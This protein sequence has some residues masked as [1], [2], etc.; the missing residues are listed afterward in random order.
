MR[1]SYSYHFRIKVYL[2]NG[3]DIVIWKYNY[4]KN[5]GHHNAFSD[6]KN[7]PCVNNVFLEPG[8]QTH[9]TL[10]EWTLP[11]GKTASLEPQNAIWVRKYIDLD[12]EYLY[13]GIHL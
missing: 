11:H 12:M 5:T 1:V 7:H 3:P 8:S 13:D 6:K 10:N 4:K 2:I 9:R